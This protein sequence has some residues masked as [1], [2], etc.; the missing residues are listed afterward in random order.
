MPRGRNRNKQLG[1]K[2]ESVSGRT[3]FT[4][5]QNVVTVTSLSP[6]SFPRALAI[7]DVYQFYRFTKADLIIPP[8][9]TQVTAGYAPG[10]AFDGVPTTAG[11]IVEFPQA[12]Y[13]GSSKTTD[14]RLHVPR[15]ELLGDSQLPWFKTIAGTPDAQFEIQGNFYCLPAV[16]GAVG[17]I[18]W[19]VEFQSWNLAAQSP[20]YVQ[21]LIKKPQ[22]KRYENNSDELIVAGVT[23]RKALA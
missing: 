5:A 12:L 1:S 13:H 20:L 4:F 11:Q 2:P 19:T 7:A 21:P 6:A 22:E 3:L 17:Y 23:Y 15:R 10:A 9:S 14:S 18:E 8:V 16:S